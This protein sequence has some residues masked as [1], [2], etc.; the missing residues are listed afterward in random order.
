MKPL[1]ALKGLIVVMLTLITTL[2]FSQSTCDPEDPYLL[3]YQYSIPSFVQ[4]YNE[5][6]C[7][8]GD[9]S[10]TTIYFK[11]YP[12]DQ[13]GVIYW[14]YSSPLGYPLTVASMSIYNSDCQL[15]SQ[16]QSVSGLG[17]SMY[18]VRFDLRTVYIDNFCPY[19][20]PINPL[21]V[22]FGTVEAKQVE[23]TIIVDWITMSE[24]NSN[25]FTIQYSYDLNKWYSTASVPSSTNS[26]TNR[27]YTSSFIPPFPGTVYIRIAEHDYNGDI[28]LSDI[29]YCSYIPKSNPGMLIYDLSGR[30]IG[31]RNF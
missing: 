10:D 28:I 25:Y 30:L 1:N 5:G 18:Y 11:F 29:V 8:S 7:I 24:A 14:G 13:N 12:E 21:A 15:I 4:L 3:I 19:F 16:G 17:N 22:D 23:N 9:I 2:S 26:S 6:Y 20:L 31:V 27:Y